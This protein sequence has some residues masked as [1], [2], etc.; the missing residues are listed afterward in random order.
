AARTS[1]SLNVQAEAVELGD[2]SVARIRVPKAQGE[3][4]T[5][6]GVSLRRRLKHD[7]TPEC[8]A[9]LPHER[10]S[11]ASSFGLID[12]SAQPV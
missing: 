4:A 9:M 12:V 7:G 11:R 10:A 3:V 1:P 8:V 5:T 2:V 6:N